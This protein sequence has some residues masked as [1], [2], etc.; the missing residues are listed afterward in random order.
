MGNGRGR[1]GVL[2]GEGPFLSPPG[3]VPL[4]YPSPIREWSQFQGTFGPIREGQPGAAQ[5]TK[6]SMAVEHA[7]NCGRYRG[8]GRW[9][10]VA[11]QRPTHHGSLQVG[12]A[13]N[14]QGVKQSLIGEPSGAPGNIT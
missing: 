6:C 3:G 11:N 1:V 14:R 9:A 12:S 8:F 7:G 5:E 13:F 2:P 4:G 10:S